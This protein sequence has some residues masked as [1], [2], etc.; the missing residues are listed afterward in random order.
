MKK[1]CVKMQ[2]SNRGNYLN[3]ARDRRASAVIFREE[4]PKD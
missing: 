2:N 4:K 3:A 1:C